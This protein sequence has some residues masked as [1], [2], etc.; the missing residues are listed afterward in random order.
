MM[1]HLRPKGKRNWAVTK[2]ALQ[3]VFINPDQAKAAIQRQIAPYCKAQWKNG[4]ERLRVTVEPEEDA[5]TV[6][7]GRY[8]WGIVLAEISEQ[9]RIDGQ[10]YT[11]D[12]WHELCKRQ[13]LPRVT[14]KTYV[15]GRKRPVVTTTIGTTK[16][17]G[18]RKMSKFIEKVIAFACTDLNVQFS[19]TRW[20]NYQ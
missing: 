18:V 19:E 20:E 9:A 3:T 5:K 2:L 15:A 16:G 7:Q 8:Y 13:H 4:I 12:A 11:V 1:L 14:K 17:I 10:Q 6:Q